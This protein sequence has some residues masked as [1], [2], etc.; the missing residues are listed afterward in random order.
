MVR[1]RS[2]IL[3]TTYQVVSVS[4]N[5]KDNLMSDLWNE[6]KWKKV[7]NGVREIKN[8][9][10]KKNKKMKIMC[11]MFVTPSS[12][13]SPNGSLVSLSFSIRSVC[14]F[15][16]ISNTQHTKMTTNKQQRKKGKDRDDIDREIQIAEWGERE[17]LS[18]VR[19]E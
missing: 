15:I 7:W 5:D 12:R 11:D 19:D 4:G 8:H 16:I 14:F 9:L 18:W 13:S 3:T 2:L 10:Q 1:K 17:K 6:I